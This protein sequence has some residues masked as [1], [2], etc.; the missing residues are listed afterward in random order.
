M[1]LMMAEALSLGK[2]SQSLPESGFWKL[3]HHHQEHVEWVGCVLHDL[4]Q[5]G[6][7]FLVGAAMAF[8]VANRTSRGQSSRQ[9][10]MH[11][12]GRSLALIFLGVFLRSVGRAQT[13]F[14]FE[15]TLSQIGLGYLFLFWLGP[16]SPKTQWIALASI[17][18]GYWLL[19]ALYPL[20]GPEFDW[21]AAGVAK[22][23]PHHLSGFAAHWNK[24]TNP[25]WAF[26]VW[27]MNLW[28]REKP[29]MF[30]GGGYSTLSFIPTLG[31][32]LL[33]LIAGR[34]LQTLTLPKER[35]QRL[36]IAGILCL[37]AGWLLG[38]AGICPVVKR[39]W[40]PSW[41]LFSGGWCFLFLA[42]FHALADVWGKRVLLFPLIVIG[43]NSIAAYC[44]DHL[45]AGFIRGSLQTHLGSGIFQ[46]LGQA[47][48]PLLRGGATLL[49]LWLILFWMH[50]RKLFLK[51]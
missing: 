47:Y 39:I 12:V 34:W 4:I 32:M 48:E 20:P 33:G 50:R 8:S 23:W 14:T 25:A 21:A 17:L 38:A 6:F 36:V 22:D 19:F 26:D 10:W 3:L 15:D 7:S 45:F 51:L 29:F 18:I 16:R 1:F 31:T 24:N 9:L 27:F 40:T 37:G 2:I 43:M 42:G 11:A 28:P 13:N 30:N 41:T 44:M 5:P 49:T 46:S 35:L